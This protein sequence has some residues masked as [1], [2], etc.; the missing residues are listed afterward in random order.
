MGGKGDII[1]KQEEAKT[2]DCILNEHV[3]IQKTCISSTV[4]EDCSKTRGLCLGR[5]NMDSDLTQ[6]HNQSQCDKQY[7]NA[8]V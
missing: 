2:K 6:H 8:W 7:N 5:K 1:K 3:Y 4:H